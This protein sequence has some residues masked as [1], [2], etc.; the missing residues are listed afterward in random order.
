LLDYEPPCNAT[1]NMTLRDCNT[2]IG[3]KT[4]C[5]GVAGSGLGY[6]GTQTYFHDFPGSSPWF[7]YFLARIAAACA[8][9]KTLRNKP[10][11]Q[12]IALR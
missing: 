11:S 7:R 5:F 10:S 4:I 3:L 12:E 6:G 8:V 9:E 2:G 1:G